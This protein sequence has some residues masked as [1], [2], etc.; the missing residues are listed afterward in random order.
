MPDGTLVEFVTYGREERNLEYKSS[1]PW[2]GAAGKNPRARVTKTCL[3]MANL[4]NG[5]TVVIGVVEKP[6]G[7]FTPVGM[8]TEHLATFTQD[9]VQAHVNEYADPYV[10]LTVTPLPLNDIGTFVLL[11]VRPFDRIPVVCKKDGVEG[12]RNGAIFTR[13]RK[14]HE[15]IE[16]PSQSEMR[17]I[18]ERATQL[19]VNLWVESNH[20]AGILIF[21]DSQVQAAAEFEKQLEG[22]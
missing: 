5:G 9:L 17:E 15:T 16:V 4:T 20:A 8:S 12:L 7:T 13:A 22:L 19:G 14:K 10:D 18:V 21:P 6:P 11:Q 1:F 2:D 3:A